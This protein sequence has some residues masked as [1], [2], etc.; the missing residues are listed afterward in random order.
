M[1]PEPPVLESLRSAVQ[2]M[3]DDVPLR[4]HLATM[5]MNAGLRDEAV[6]HV[7]AILQRDPGNAA[8]LALL[9]VPAS[10]ASQDQAPQPDVAPGQDQAPHQSQVPHQGQ[11][12][13]QDLA[14]DPEQ[15]PGFDWSQAESDVQGLLPPMFV[16]DDPAADDDPAA[17]AFDVEQ[18]GLRLADV[19]GMTEVKQRLEA[20]FLA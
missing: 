15:A 10:S 6:R 9:Q 14:S 1:E 2:A 16:S 13:G 4:V 17:R 5:L 19:A 20:A 11:A 3:P 12:P 18:T 7:G 8:A